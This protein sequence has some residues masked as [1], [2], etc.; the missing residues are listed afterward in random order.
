MKQEKNIIR[1]WI[2]LGILLVC[3]NVVVFFI[4]FRKNALFAVSWLFTM[5][6]IAAQIYVIRT[7]FCNGK[8]V[9]SKFYGFP[10]AKLGMGYLAVQLVLSFAFM[11]LGCSRVAA[12]GAVCGIAGCRSGWTDCRRGHSGCGEP[13]GSTAG[14]ADCPDAWISGK[15]AGAGGP[16]Y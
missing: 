3:Y 2:V 13:S 8:S 14:Q 4:P 1:S 11:A 6:A 12:A 7:A 10:I 15:S 16:N 5:L 9:K